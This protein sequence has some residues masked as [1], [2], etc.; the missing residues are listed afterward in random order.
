MR[1]KHR[2]NT[3][4]LTRPHDYIQWTGL[5]TEAPGHNQG[6]SEM[7]LFGHQAS[8][9][10]CGA[11]E[12]ALSAQKTQWATDDGTAS[13]SINCQNSSW[14]RRRRPSGQQMMEEHQPASTARILHGTKLVQG[15]I[16]PGLRHGEAKPQI[17]TKP[18]FKGKLFTSSQELTDPTPPALPPAM[19][20]RL[21]VAL[22]PLQFAMLTDRRPILPDP[23]S[24]RFGLRSDPLKA[25]ERAHYF[26][27]WSAPYAEPPPRHSIK[28][29]MLCSIV[30]TPQG[31]LTLL[32]ANILEKG[33]GT[34]PN[35][36]G[37]FRIRGPLF[38][39][40][41]GSDVNQTLFYRFENQYSEL[42]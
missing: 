34:D 2:L 8:A 26:M 6:H 4:R 40:L 25:F 41:R 20:L 35:R 18:R 17:T 37:Y 33:D 11:S 28:K 36:A 14:H 1:V 15:Y 16:F 42:A 22:S 27:S 5:R 23:Y 30:F 10:G 9:L 19:E 31:V 29:Y 38:H 7:A 3:R 32:L 13:I 12:K 21:F 39:E 24:L